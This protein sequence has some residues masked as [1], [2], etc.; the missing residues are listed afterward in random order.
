MRRSPLIA[1]ALVAFSVSAAAEEIEAEK[2]LFNGA[3]LHDIGQNVLNY[4]L[5]P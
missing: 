1:A 4:L 3:E 5:G 2:N